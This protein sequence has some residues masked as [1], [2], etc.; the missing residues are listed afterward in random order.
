MFIQSTK[1]LFA[2]LFIFLNAIAY[3]QTTFR[4]IVIDAKSK[5]PIVEA[6]IGISNQGVGEIT[7]NIGYFVYTKHNEVLEE[8]SILEISA[9]GYKSIIKKRE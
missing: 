1:I 2:L 4:G 6:K 5:K 7:N 3:S 8:S 9:L